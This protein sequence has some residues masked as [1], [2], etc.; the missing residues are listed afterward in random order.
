MRFDPRDQ[1]E[2]RCWRD[3]TVRLHYGPGHG[4]IIKISEDTI[5]SGRPVFAKPRLLAQVVF[6]DTIDLNSSELPYDQV[7]YSRHRLAVYDDVDHAIDLYDYWICEG[8]PLPN[9]GNQ[10]LA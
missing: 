9:V 7:Y 3:R 10:R 2:V 8:Y 5:W 6:S 1:P 4:R